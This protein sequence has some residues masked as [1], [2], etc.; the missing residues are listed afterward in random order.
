[1][2]NGTFQSILARSLAVLCLLAA[3]PSAAAAAPVRA[4][5][6][7]AEI[8][9]DHAAIA[10]GGTIHVALRQQIDAGWHTYWR[11]PGDSGEATTLDW[12][13]PAG[14]K[15]GAIVW[16]TPRQLQIG[17]LMDYGYTGEVLL[18]LAL[19]APAGA[20][21][22]QTVTLKAHAAF[23][24]C[25]DVCVP[26]DAQLSLDLPVAAA[27]PP[28]EPHWGPAI[29]AT[30]AAAPRASPALKAAMTPGAAAVKLSIAGAPLKG[31]DVA[32]AY[33]YPY[34]GEAIDAAQPQAIE[35][36]PDG[37]TLS[38]A[39]GSAFK[40]GKPPANLTGVLA[41]KSAA[42]EVTAAPGP[43]LADASGLGPPPGAP[44]GL[45]QFAV[46]MGLAFVG[47]LILNLMPCVFPIL[48]MKAASLARHAHAPNAARIQGLAYLAGVVA[49]FLA[50]AG[51][52]IAARA[53]GQAVGW[54]FQLQSSVILGGLALV[55][56]LVALN[57]SGVFEAGTALQAAAGQAEAADR[58]GAL[59][60]AL[61]GVLAVAVAAPCTAPFMGAAVG[62]A[63]TQGTAIALAVFLALGLGMAAPFVALAFAPALLGRLP[64][65][66]AWMEGLKKALAFPMYATAAWLA[67]VYAQSAGSTRLAGLFAAAVLTG[68]AAWLYGAGQRARITGARSAPALAASAIAIALA[69]AAAFWPAAPTPAALASQPFSPDRLAELRAEHRP[70]FVNFTAAWCVT[71]QVNDRVAL[72]GGKTADAFGR[73]GV[74]YLVG[75]WTDRDAAIEQALAA[76]GRAG[77]PLY[78][79]Y[80]ADGGEPQVLPQILTEGMVVDA[81]KKA[82]ASAS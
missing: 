14:W 82:A 62:F 20:R 52:L 35:R 46:A 8:V 47:G 73:A 64:R 58:G 71:C 79:M 72:S 70:V 24:V 33:F 1:M 63:L 60:A 3:V 38:L 32:G 80:P 76:H 75:D 27:N 51:A 21:P 7:T 18:P 9:A 68:L 22:G 40:T 10:P 23:L 39:P 31:A 48:A 36:G 55:M 2:V 50:L 26:E 74:V 43:P 61:T 59:G 19:T 29:A 16:P 42:F 28:A 5:H 65:P 13:L 15:T 30:L 78:L 4:G 12:T 56:L 57:L 66:G 53:A 45:G 34:D 44:A 67:W 49:T 41:L 81:A 54:G 6:L 25:Q 37:L 17:P 11:N 77:V 69:L